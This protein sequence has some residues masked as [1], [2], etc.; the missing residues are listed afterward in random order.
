[1]AEIFSFSF[2]WHYS[3][4]SSFCTLKNSILHPLEGHF[5]VPL[6]FWDFLSEKHLFSFFHTFQLT[7]QNEGRRVHQKEIL[8]MTGSPGSQLEKKLNPHPTFWPCPNRTSVV[9]LMTQNV[10]WGWAE[11]GGKGSK[12][13]S[14]FT[15][16]FSSLAQPSQGTELLEKAGVVKLLLRSPVRMLMLPPDT[17]WERWKLENTSLH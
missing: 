7:V 3:Q 14:F 10:Q 12:I 5:K 13:P 11:V 15:H 6:F 1:M 16:A 9:Q 8:G 17:P 4:D 2:L